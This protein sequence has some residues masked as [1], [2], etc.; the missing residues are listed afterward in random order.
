LQTFLEPREGRDGSG[1]SCSGEEGFVD[2]VVSR[3]GDGPFGLCVAKRSPDLRHAVRGNRRLQ[4]GPGQQR[5]LFLL[6]LPVLLSLFD[7]RY[8]NRRK[9]FA[10]RCWDLVEF[11]TALIQSPRS[12]HNRRTLFT[13][14]A[15]SE[16]AAVRRRSPSARCSKQNHAVTLAR[17]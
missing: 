4:I 14:H 9:A 3:R 8:S 13:A 11:I 5:L 15:I 7:F 16:R 17:E 1:V 2:Q 6:Q 10:S 12:Q